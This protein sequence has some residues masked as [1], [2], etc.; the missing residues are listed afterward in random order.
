MKNAE[1]IK[2]LESGESPETL[3]E[4][5]ENPFQKCVVVLFFK[6][7]ARMEAYEKDIGWLKKITIST[8]GVVL[9]ALLTQYLAPWIQNLFV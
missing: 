9:L 5:A 7:D 8:F 4:L 6:Q 3:L 1:F 2:L